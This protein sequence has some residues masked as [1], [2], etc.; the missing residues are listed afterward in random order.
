MIREDQLGLDRIYLQAKRCAPGKTIGPEAVQAFIGALVG[1]GA[2][3][4]ML[5]ATSGFTTRAIKAAAQSGALRLILIDGEMLTDLMIRLNV[6]GRI[7][8]TLEIKRVDQDYFG[9][10]EPE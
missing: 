4:G 7:A 6:G 3:K 5:I 2:H 1:R 9:E 8:S 10:S